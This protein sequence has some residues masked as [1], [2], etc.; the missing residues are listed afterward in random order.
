MAE[1][2][3]ESILQP[4]VFLLA[5]QAALVLH[6]WTHCATALAL[7]APRAAIHVD[8]GMNPHVRV[9]GLSATPIRAALVRHAG[10]CFSLLFAITASFTH[11]LLPLSCRVPLLAAL[12]LTATEAV[13]SD[14][15]RQGASASTDERFGCGNFGIVMLDSAGRRLLLPALRRMMR[16]TMMRGAQSAGYVTYRKDPFKRRSLVGKRRRVVSGKRTDMSRQLLASLPHASA[17]EQL[18]SSLRGGD[19]EPAGPEVYQGHTCVQRDSKGASCGA[20]GD[21]FV[22]ACRDCCPPPPR[23]DRSQPWDPPTHTAQAVRY[24]VARFVRRLPPP[25]FLSSEHAAGVAVRR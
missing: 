20:C 3:G 11:V 24:L 23:S 12:W 13:R 8:L 16:V 19:H 2:F 6:E 10:W 18:A 25:P 14:L 5:H 22:C 1:L 17:I 21:W 9:D 7:G 4:A 15:L